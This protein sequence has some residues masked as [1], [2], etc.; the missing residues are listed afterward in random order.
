MPIASERCTWSATGCLKV[1]RSRQTAIRATSAKRPKK[2][3]VSSSQS[4]PERRT[5][6]PQRARP[7]RRLP[8]A[9]PRGAT[10]AGGVWRGRDGAATVA[11]TPLAVAGTAGGRISASGR[12]T[13]PDAAAWGA[14]AAG[15]CLGLECVTEGGVCGEWPAGVGAVAASTAWAS[16]FAAWR[17]PIPRTRPKR[18]LSIPDQFI[19]CHVAA[20]FGRCTL[21]PRRGMSPREPGA[22]KRRLDGNGQEEKTR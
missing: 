8:S 21:L 3:P 20:V 11:R 10:E 1:P 15:A 17:A 22:S 2:T 18:A 13:G 5:A 19:A 12:R 16:V 14:V 7:K 9:R 6:G 4:T